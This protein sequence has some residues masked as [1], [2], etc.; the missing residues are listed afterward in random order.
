MY[1]L[2]LQSLFAHFELMFQTRECFQIAI[3]QKI[4]DNSICAGERIQ[5]SKNV[6]K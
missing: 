3:E 1:I 6:N 5:N 2:Q 4:V